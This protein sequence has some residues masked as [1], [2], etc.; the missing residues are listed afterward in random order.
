MIAAGRDFG[1][2]RVGR[3]LRISG[4]PVTHL[5]GA[6][7]SRARRLLGTR[8][9]QLRVQRK[10]PVHLRR[11]EPTRVQRRQ[12]LRQGLLQPFGGRWFHPHRRVHRR[13]L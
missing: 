5:L 6:G 11:Q 8:P 3:R 9:V 10:R 13:R 1:F 7:L 4:V 2:S 12:R